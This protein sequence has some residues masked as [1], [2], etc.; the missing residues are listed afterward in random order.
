VVVAGLERNA[1]RG[2]FES[3]SESTRGRRLG[4]DVVE[5]AGFGLEGS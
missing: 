3:G 1:G 4:P 2:A 5:D